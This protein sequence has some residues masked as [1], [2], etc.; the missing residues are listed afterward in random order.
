MNPPQ[1]KSPACDWSSSWPLLRACLIVPPLPRFTW[2]ILIQQIWA[3]AQK[4]WFRM[5]FIGQSFPAMLWQTPGVKRSVEANR[6]QYS[7]YNTKNKTYEL[8]KMFHLL[9]P[10]P[11]ER[12]R[13]SLQCIRAQFQA[14]WS[15][16]AASKSRNNVEGEQDGQA[17]TTLHFYHAL[18]SFSLLS[19]SI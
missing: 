9:P 10:R 6:T 18:N 17:E 5:R 15:D 3:P 7:D 13:D 12:T 4:N 19:D 11:G 1:R 8:Y 16:N 14:S 2:N